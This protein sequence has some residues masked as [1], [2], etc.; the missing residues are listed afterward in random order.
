MSEWWTWTGQSLSSV[1]SSSLLFQFQ[2][3]FQ[4]RFLNPNRIKRMA[5]ISMTWS[6]PAK[7]RR[8]NRW[9]IGI[10]F[11]VFSLFE[12][13]ALIAFILRIHSFLFILY[14]N[15]YL[16][17]FISF[18]FHFLGNVENLFSR[19]KLTLGTE[20]RECR[21]QVGT[22]KRHVWECSLLKV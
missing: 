4:F 3:Q 6:L 2:F 13:F 16:F 14:S 12:S 20:L 1:L 7:R 11:P 21:L 15:F 22:K 5:S 17:Y 19:L 10:Q 8:V 9:V 18:D